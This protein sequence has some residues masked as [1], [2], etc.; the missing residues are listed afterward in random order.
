M[1]CIL[2]VLWWVVFWLCFDGLYCCS[3]LMS[4]I[5][6]VFWRVVFWLCFDRLFI[7]CILM[8][9]ILLV[10][11]WAIFCLCFDVCI[12][13]SVLKGCILVVFC[14]VV[15]WFVIL[16]VVYWL[17]FD[18]LYFACVFTGCIFV[19][20]VKKKK[21]NAYS[22]NNTMKW[23]AVSCFLY[24]HIVVLYSLG[25]GTVFIR[26]NLTSVD[27]RFWRIKTVPALLGF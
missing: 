13:V 19:G 14:W 20:V 11:W 3:V 4:C 15:F 2:V 6:L 8:G 16:W 10:F 25:P 27:V 23:C 5:L 18:R 7:G 26:Q 9:C 24:S 22:T 1:G 17:S 12:L 21:R